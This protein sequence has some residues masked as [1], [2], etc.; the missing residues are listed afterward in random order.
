M[1]SFTYNYV[2][3]S[4]LSTNSC[5]FNLVPARFVFMQTQVILGRKGVVRQTE[6]NH[7]WISKLK[8]G[9]SSQEL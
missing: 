7:S 1:S 3:Q 5:H 6:L 2:L 8:G 4:T 9:D